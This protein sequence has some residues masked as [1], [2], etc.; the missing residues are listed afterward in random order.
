MSDSAPLSPLTNPAALRFKWLLGIL[1]ATALTAI[2]AVQLPD[3]AK[4]IGLFPLIWGGLL[5]FGY[6]WWAGECHLPRARWMDIT[7]FLVLAVGE[8]AIVYQAWQL[9]QF[10]LRQQFKKDPAAGMV[11]QAEQVPSEKIKP[12]EQALRKQLL[13]EF[14]RVRQR[15]R[16]ALAMPTFLQRRL[17]KLGD[18]PHPWPEVF[19]A[20]EILLGGLAGLTVMKLTWPTTQNTKQQDLQHGDTESTG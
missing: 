3:R 1:I 4:L 7:A 15:R 19:Y 14:E 16:E 11:K 12:E 20:A 10:E 13:A 6:A 18:I 8:A 9:Y 5:G 17:R 2:L